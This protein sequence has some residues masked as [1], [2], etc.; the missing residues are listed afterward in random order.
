MSYKKLKL[1][2]IKNYVENNIGNFHKKR[3]GES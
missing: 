1:D 2:V 3:M